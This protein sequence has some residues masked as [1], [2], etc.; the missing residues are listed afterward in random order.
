MGQGYSA[1]ENTEFEKYLVH[2]NDAIKD[3]QP[4]EKFRRSIAVIC[5]DLLAGN[6]LAN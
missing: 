3:T 1:K 4:Y 5:K 6:R 2:I